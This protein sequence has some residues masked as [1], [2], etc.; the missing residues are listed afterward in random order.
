MSNKVTNGRISYGQ[1]KLAD[2]MLF[3]LIMCVCE[4]INVFAVR[5]WFSGMLFSISVM[6]LVTLIVLIRWNWL[7]VLFPVAD[8]LI[9]CWMN[10]A[11][12]WQ[13]ATY[14]IGNAFICLVWLAFLV[15]PKEKITSSWILTILYA[16][17]GFILYVLGRALIALFFGKNFG[18]IFVGMLTAEALNL[19][20]AVLG[21]LIL[22]KLDGML[23]DQKKYLFK[24]QKERDTIKRA[25]EYRWNGY[26]ELNEDDL[27]QLVAMDEYDRAINFNARSLRELKENDGHDQAEEA[28]EEPSETDELSQLDGQ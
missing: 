23:V 15:I 17:V 10:G 12:G 18:E 8:G 14:A 7:G 19:A 6:S 27:R 26:T 11:E 2:V 21:L 25:E 13:F 28:E 24:V 3:L 4:V 22:R 20:F 5:Q 16:A 9:Y 1:Y